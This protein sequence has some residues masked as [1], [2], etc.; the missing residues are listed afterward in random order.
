MTRIT[1]HTAKL[2]DPVWALRRG[3]WKEAIIVGR[4]RELCRIEFLD[5]GNRSSRRY[6]ELAGRSPSKN[7]SDKPADPAKG[8]D[9]MIGAF[10]EMSA[11]H[12]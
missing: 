4:G 2:H 12:E 10:V 3:H 1:W 11:R 9:G 8:L 5:N 7:P 6:E